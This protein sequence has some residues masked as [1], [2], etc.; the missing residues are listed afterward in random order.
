VWAT[1]HVAP[2]RRRASSPSPAGGRGGRRTG[3]RRPPTPDPTLWG[4]RRLLLPV[5]PPRRAGMPRAP[6]VLAPLRR[7]RGGGGGGGGGAERAEAAGD[8]AAALRIPPR[9]RPRAP[10]A[11]PSRL[12]LSFPFVSTKLLQ[13]DFVGRFYW[14]LTA[15][16]L[17]ASGSPGA[18]RGDSGHEGE[19]DAG[20]SHIC[21]VALCSS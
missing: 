9:Q 8:D 5:K 19:P 3:A 10:R 2:P 12:R 18:P 15:P 7:R 14:T 20:A 13:C 6:H 16:S 11:P 4:L 21:I 17:M 1:S